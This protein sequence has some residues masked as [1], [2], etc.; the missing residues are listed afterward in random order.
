MPASQEELI[1]QAIS[2]EGENCFPISMSIEHSNPSRQYLLGLRVNRLIIELIFRAIEKKEDGTRPCFRII[3]N[4]IWN[5]I[6]LCYEQ[7]FRNK[8]TSEEG[9]IYQSLTNRR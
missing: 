5:S 6:L 1:V 9:K 4:L 3:D 7:M 8:N 2:V